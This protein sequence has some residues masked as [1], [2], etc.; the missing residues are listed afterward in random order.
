MHKVNILIAEDDKD[1]FQLLREAIENVLPKF[2]I[3]HSRDGK[4]FS[5]A[6]DNGLEPDLV[7]LDLNMPYK[8][9]IECLVEFRR[10]E[11]LQQTP[12]IIYSTSSHFEDIDKCY[13]SGCTLYMV[14]PTSFRDLVTQIKKV[15]FR[16]GLPKKELLDKEMFV[17]KKQEG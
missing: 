6:I 14:K 4:E 15:F 3:T 13:K 10:K 17:V 12:V 9:G 1:D 2:D 7:F 11:G 16:I 5:Q 8:S